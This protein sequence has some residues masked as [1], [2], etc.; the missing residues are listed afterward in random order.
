MLYRS[1]Q[2]YTPLKLM[3]IVDDLWV[4]LVCVGQWLFQQ[5]L[6]SCWIS[7]FASR[8]PEPVHDQLWRRISACMSMMGSCERQAL[9][10]FYLWRFLLSSQILAFSSFPLHKFTYPPQIPSPQ[11]QE[12]TVCRGNGFILDYLNSYHDFMKSNGYNL[13]FYNTLEPNVRCNQKTSTS[14]HSDFFNQISDYQDFRKL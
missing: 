10:P 3:Y 7:S 4:L 13:L 2:S 8:N 5:L 12:N 6:S 9:L 14:T 1:G 11:L